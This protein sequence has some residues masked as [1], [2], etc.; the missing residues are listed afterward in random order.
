M[1]FFRAFSVLRGY[2]SLFIGWISMGDETREKTFGVVRSMYLSIGARVRSFEC[3]LQSVRCR[4][5][6]ELKPAVHRLQEVRGLGLLGAKSHIAFV[7][8]QEFVRGRS[9]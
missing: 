8:G 6:L 4:E 7:Q 5:S 2:H 1:F 3:E 9:G